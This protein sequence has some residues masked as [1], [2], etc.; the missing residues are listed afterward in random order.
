MSTRFICKF[1]LLMSFSIQLHSL[2]FY[3]EYFRCIAG[4]F[5]WHNNFLPSVK[6]YSRHRLSQI[7]LVQSVI[8]GEICV[9]ELS[10]VSS[11]FSC[12]WIHISCLITN[13]LTSCTSLITEPSS[14]YTRSNPTWGCDNLSDRLECACQRIV[15]T[16]HIDTFTLM[17]VNNTCS[18]ASKNPLLSW[19]LSQSHYWSI[20]I[21]DASKSTLL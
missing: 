6:F 15:I 9:L 20:I 2:S 5:L 13:L 14:A 8:F 18:D 16:E 17:H 19:L 4:K 3:E 21:N 7:F 1:W 10:A 11:L 12:N